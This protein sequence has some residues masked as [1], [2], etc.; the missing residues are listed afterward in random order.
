MSQ[1]STTRTVGR[2]EGPGARSS[3][4]RSTSRRCFTVRAARTT[5]GR[6]NGSPCAPC[7]SS[8]SSSGLAAS[9][10]AD[11]DTERTVASRRSRTCPRRTCRPPTPRPRTRTSSPSRGSGRRSASFLLH[12]HGDHRAARQGPSQVCR[13]RLPPKQRQDRSPHVQWIEPRHPTLDLS[14]V[15]PERP[16]ADTTVTHSSSRNIDRR[17]WARNRRFAI[18]TASPPW[19]TS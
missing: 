11:V 15:I 12:R 9:S 2:Q 7:P 19:N 4:W 13:P 18:T 5:V 8:G 14:N 6:A 17:P 1:E 16:A 3:T 10:S